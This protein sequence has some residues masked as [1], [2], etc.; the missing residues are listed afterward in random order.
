M[1]PAALSPFLLLA[2]VLAPLL[3]CAKSREAT[4]IPRRDPVYAGMVGKW[5]GTLEVRDVF[6]HSRR[7]TRP[8]SVLVR[9]VPEADALEMRIA[10]GVGP[11]A[12]PVTTDRLQLDKAVTAARWG[13]ADDQTPQQFD[14]KV[15]EAPESPTASQPLRLVL[16]RFGSVDDLPATIRETVTIAPGEIH[17]VQ[18]AR[19]TGPD[20]IFQRAYTLRR[21]G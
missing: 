9:P 2:S 4:T 17:I 8:A 16:E 12:T 3:A 6:D 15:H 10:T 14:V 11:S 7:V 13:D 20:F 1:R 5:Q 18:E 19:T 21:V